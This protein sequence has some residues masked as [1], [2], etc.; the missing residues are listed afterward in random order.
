[1]AF[2]APLI[3]EQ[4]LDVNGKPLAG[5]KIWVYLAGTSTPATTYSDKA[6][7]V[8]NTNPIVLNS[9]GVNVQGSVWLTGGSAYKFVITDS[10]GTLQ[11]TID[12]VSGV[13]DTTVAADQWVVYQG[14]PTYVSATSFTVPGDQT[15]IFQVGRRV[16]TTNTGGTAYGTITNSVYSAPNTTV[17]VENTSGV[18]DSGLSSVS[19][20]LISVLDTSLPP[21]RLLRTLVYSR[22]AGVQNVSINGGAPSTTG[23]ATYTPSAAAAFALVESVGGGGGGG[24]AANPTAG[25]VSIGAPGTSGTY[26]KAYFSASTLGASQAVVVGAGG[27]GGAGVAGGT[28]GSTSLGALL[29]CPGGP[30]GT[31]LNSQSAPLVLGGAGAAAATGANLYTSIGGVGLFT[32]AITATVSAMWGGSGGGNVFGPGAPQAAGNTNGTS[33]TAPGTGGAGV[34]LVNGGGT[35]TGGAGASGMVVIYEYA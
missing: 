29:V 9:L 23:A 32:T 19:Y 14:V 18:L 1:M 2:L 15:Q 13:N 31:V 21:G 33:A 6:G 30:A 5:G 8:P 35:G 4:Q 12:D 28:G 20:G 25:L 17:T 27:T 16:K 3:N 10:L 34:A 24:G 7:L 26:G 22:I 11:R